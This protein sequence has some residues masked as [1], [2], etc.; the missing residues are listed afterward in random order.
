M[1]VADVTPENQVRLR[2]QVDKWKPGQVGFHVFRR[3]VDPDGKP[4]TWER[5]AEEV[6]APDL[7]IERLKK[8]KL[9]NVLAK[10]AQRKEGDISTPGI[11]KR[12]SENGGQGVRAAVMGSILDYQHALAFGL[13]LVVSGVKTN[14]QYEFGVARAFEGQ[15]ADTK[16]IFATARLAVR[17]GGFECPPILEFKASREIQKNVVTIAW[18]IRK[19][20]LAAR[21]DI[22]AFAVFKGPPDQPLEQVMARRHVD[23][24]VTTPQD[25]N[26]HYMIADTK[27]EG[28]AIKYALAPINRFGRMGQL[29]ARVV[30]G[31]KGAKLD[32][33]TNIV[34]K[35]EPEGVVVT[36]KH[37]HPADSRFA[38]FLVTRRGVKQDEKEAVL[39]R[40][41]LPPY[42]R[43]FVDRAAL[44]DCR[45]L[46]LLYWVTAISG[47]ERASSKDMCPQPVHV[48]F[49]KPPTP[50]DFS[51]RAEVKDDKTLVRCRWTKVES[52]GLSGYVI[53]R[54]VPDDGA[55]I[56]C[57][58]AGNEGEATIEIETK[59]FPWTLVL[60]VRA[61]AAG[62]VISD[63]GQEISVRMPPAGVLTAPAT[64]P[65]VNEEAGAV[66]F[67]WRDPASA[68]TQGYR[69]LM[70]GKVLADEGV[71]GG[72]VRRW[73][74]WTIPEGKHVFG[75]MKV[76]RFGRVSAAKD[77]EPTVVGQDRS[78][79]AGKSL[80]SMDNTQA[81]V[82]RTYFDA[83]KTRLKAVT[84]YRV[85]PDG[86]KFKHGVETVYAESFPPDQPYY[87]LSYVQG[88]PHGVYV[89]WKKDGSIFNVSFN[90]KGQSAFRKEYV[91]KCGE[92]ALTDAEKEWLK[93][94]GQ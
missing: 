78:K 93:A 20:D 21:R 29:S 43:R 62:N 46:D 13:G 73:T 19:A 3:T 41:P 55:W 54:L 12:F 63:P 84:E 51:A 56:Q 32:P 14:E 39:T 47:D 31:L 60:R 59:A 74:S 87:R 70:D 40:E 28:E 30:V 68:D 48:P 92:P 26:V 67:T 7:S 83:A 75:L 6:V 61:M 17:V 72:Y 35:V 77:A 38:G 49:P 11:L 89:Q 22:E 65:T 37:S 23:N 57:G 9:D 76:D 91:Q 1:L 64:H 33:P 94:H 52:P 85:A 15:K 4:S 71:L 8:L 25:E 80:P 34:A 16:D 24:Y 44:V 82:E 81:V 42:H 66:T 69:L 53:Q 90:I 36:W 5:A 88:E 50:P 79:D 45:G 10:M 27:A 18:S 58:A 2:W 86:T